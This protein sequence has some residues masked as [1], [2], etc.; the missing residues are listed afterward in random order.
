M[1]LLIADDHELL[2]DTLRSFLQQQDGLEIWTVGDLMEAV[3]KLDEG[4]RYDLILLDYT[5]PGMNGLEGLKFLLERPDTP[6]VALISG[7]AEPDVAFR[8]MQLGA[9]GFLQK[10]MP[11]RS[12]L[13]AIRFMAEGERFMPV[14]VALAAVGGLVAPERPATNRPD[15]SLTPR[16]TEVLAAL[17]RGLT[18]KEI[19]RSM[20]LSEPTIKLHVKTLYRRLGATNRTQAAM[21]ARNMGLS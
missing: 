10:T 12:L 13:N 14:E 7:I 16:E 18:N 15:V 19:A 4:A 9:Q 5:M 17:C 2:R 3:A 1:R 21:I 6:P 8:A 11:A 20:D